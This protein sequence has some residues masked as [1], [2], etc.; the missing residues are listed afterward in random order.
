MAFDKLRLSGLFAYEPSPRPLMLS[1]SKHHA[2]AGL[3][4]VTAC[5]QPGV[6]APPGETVPC[7]LDGAA[8]FAPVCGVEREIVPGGTI[9]VIRHPDGGFRR[10]EIEGDLVRTADGAEAVTVTPS[11][12]ATEVAVGTDRYRLAPPA[13]PVDADGP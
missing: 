6:E 5:S 3:L 8:E 4:A 9:L 10:F 1:L 11:A 2:L 7:A 13:P 12:E